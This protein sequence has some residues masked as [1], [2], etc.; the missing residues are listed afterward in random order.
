MTTSDAIGEKEGPPQAMPL[1]RDDL[2]FEE[3]DGEA[4]L[5]DPGCGA[6]HRFNAMTLF[7]WGACDGLHS[8]AGIVNALTERYAITS[9]EARGH[10]ERVVAEFRKRDLLQEEDAEP[11][12]VVS[13]ERKPSKTQR[14]LDKPRGPSRRELLSGGVTK[15]VFMAPVIST[16]VATGAHAVASNPINPNY[17]ATGA[18]GCANPG[19]SC[20]ANADCCGGGTALTGCEGNVCCIK[21]NKSG[22]F[23]DSDC[24]SGLTCS[25]GTCIDS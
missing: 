3:L 11:A 10:V 16:F 4:V 9:D 17:S 15:L 21:N 6:V 14:G 18:G 19:Y 12:S 23:R 24:C 7:V 13:S 2:F 8:T 1:R 25:A 5:Y 22:C 20:T